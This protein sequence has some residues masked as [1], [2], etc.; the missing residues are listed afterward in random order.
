MQLPIWLR[1][2]MPLM[3]MSSVLALTAGSVALLW[4]L[5]RA[6]HPGI[7]FGVMSGGAFAL[8]FFPSFFGVLAPALMLLNLCVRGVP[9]LRRIFEENSK[10]VHG[11]SYQDSMSRLRKLAMVLVPLALVLALIGAVEPWAS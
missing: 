8:I 2:L 3:V 9:P 7:S 11:A 10:G 6:L 4:S 1:L 5:H